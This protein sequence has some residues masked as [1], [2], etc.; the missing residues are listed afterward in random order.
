MEG[1]GKRVLVADNCAESRGQ[2]ALLLALHDYNVHVAY[3]GADLLRQMGARRFDV[4]IMNDHLPGLT[5]TAFVAL[6][7]PMWPDSSIIVMA[8]SESEFAELALRCKADAE[9]CKTYDTMMLLKTVQS[10][11]NRLHESN[12]ERRW[13]H[14]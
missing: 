3:D 9:I 1:Y 13:S 5:S 6:G 2:L 10:A 11:A 4:V 12:N 14:L 8:H 7:Q